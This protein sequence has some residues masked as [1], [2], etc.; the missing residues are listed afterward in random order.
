MVSKVRTMILWFILFT[1]VSVGFA[2][3]ANAALACGKFVN[4][5]AQ[6][7][8]IGYYLNSVAQIPRYEPKFLDP[9]AEAA[10]SDKWAGV[11]EGPLMMTQTLHEKTA[12]IDRPLLAADAGT[13][14]SATAASYVSMRLRHEWN[15]KD[16]ST[17][18][19]VSADALIAKTL[20]GD[21]TKLVP[22]SAKAVFIFMHGWG[23]KTTGHHVAAAFSNFM[24]PYGVVVLS[25]DAPHHAYGP[26]VSELSPKEYATYL[27]DFRNEFVPESVPTFI[28]GHSGG[29]YIADMMMRFSDDSALGLK[30][31]FKG[32]IN[33][34]GPMDAAP[35][36]SAA[37]KSAAEDLITSNEELMELVPEAERDL[38][39]LLLTQG[40]TSATSGL[41]AEGFMSSVNWE[42]PKHN[43][44]DYLPTLVVMGERD[45]LYIGKEKI[46]QEHLA[47]LTNTETHVMGLRPNFKGSESWVSHMIFDHY[48]VGTKDPE[49][50]H[51]VKDFIETQ[52]GTDLP[53]IK[54]SS[55]ISTSQASKVGIIVNVVQEYYNNLAFRRFAHEFELVIKKA[56]PEIQ[57]FGRKMGEL[58][59]QFGQLTGKIKQL[60]KNNPD[61]SEI[62]ELQKEADAIN[63]ELQKTKALLSSEY[64]PEGENKDFAENNLA[65]R[66]ETETK[67]DAAIRSKQS[68]SKEL[69]ILREQVQKHQKA[70]EALVE[71]ILWDQ[72]LQTP[73]ALAVHQNIEK[74]LQVMIDLQIKMNDVNSALVSRNTEDGVTAVNPGPEEIAVY[75]ELDAA[76][77]DYN[78]AMAEGR[79]VVSEAVG[80][81]ATTK[82]ELELFN[83][84]YGSVEAFS[85]NTPSDESL[86]GR[87]QAKETEVRRAEADVHRLTLEREAS[88]EAYIE[89]VTPGLYT[90]STTRLFDELNKPMSTLV[91]SSSGVEALW[92]VWSEIWKERP[93][94]QGTSLY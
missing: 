33:L 78:I 24:A 47:D 81:G 11:Q 10:L 53:K 44:A 3:S 7:R 5:A 74:K 45:A 6:T 86:L 54:G 93:P 21:T 1:S 23:T 38:S 22:S 87:T 2:D 35:G 75:K 41:S 29:G 61:D 31:A 73:D 40:K 70:F 71:K 84:L 13:V 16:M 82:E 25:I 46:F 90:F 49:T 92:R 48:R 39:V 67:V 62:A 28:G 9:K 50:F 27:R 83:L 77:A 18:L 19:G 94:E 79:K 14:K 72:S 51:V 8:N 17:N 37:E 4:S 43:G 65:D 52:V 56:S 20:E 34:S 12:F 60:K 69:R 63:T 30:N 32:A 64:I 57:G 80:E 76:Y 42:K 88:I 89:R 66:R 15:G 58:S 85:N 36:K 91:D 26:R 59:K 55:L 68:G